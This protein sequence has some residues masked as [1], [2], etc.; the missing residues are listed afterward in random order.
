MPYNKPP[1]GAY[2]ILRVLEE[3][4]SQHRC[5][6]PRLGSF[7]SSLVFPYFRGQV[8]SGEAF[9]KQGVRVRVSVY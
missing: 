4:K 2:F 1:Q 9:L 8:E 5:Q 7:L 3:C 6:N